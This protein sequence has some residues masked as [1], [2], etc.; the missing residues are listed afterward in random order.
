MICSRDIQE[1][2]LNSYNLYE[3][4]FTSIADDSALYLY[5]DRLRLPLIFYYGHTSAV[6]VNKLMLADLLTKRIN[7]EF[8]TIFETGVDEMFWDDTV[9][10]RIDGKPIV[11]PEVVDVT[12]YR[13]QVKNAILQ[14]INDTPLELPITMESKWWALL[15]GMAHERIHLETSSVLIRQL[16]VNVVTKPP[17]WVYAEMKTGKPVGPNSLVALEGR[18]VQLGKPRNFPSYGWDNEYG[19]SRCL[20]PDFEATKYLVTNEEFLKFVTDKGYERQELWSDIGWKWRCFRSA[21]HPT[22]WVCNKGCKSGCGETLSNYTHCQ[23]RSSD[24]LNEPTFCYRA[25]FDV[26]TLPRDWPVEVNY[27]E[28]KAYCTWM[29]PGY[30]LPTEAEAMLMKGTMPPITERVKCDI[31]HSG[32]PD[33]NINFKYG[34]PSNGSWI[35]T[36]NEASRFARYAFRRHFFQHLGFRMVKSS[37]DI[38]VKLIGPTDQVTKT[39]ELENGSP[40]KSYSQ[41]NVSANS[42]YRY[43]DKLVIEDVLLQE[44]GFKNSLDAVALQKGLSLMEEWSIPAKTALV[45]GSSSGRVAF[46]MSKTFK[47]VLGIDYSNRLLSVAEK[48]KS[49]KST[50]IPYSLGKEVEI[51]PSWSRENVIFKQLTWL[52]MELGSHNMV[53]VTFLERLQNTKAWLYRLWELLKDD[54]LLVITS[55]DT[56]WTAAEL[57]Q[58]LQPR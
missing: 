28:A 50:I 9:N 12:A 40:V 45:L 6:Y 1:Y 13:R 51:D 39:S 32:K 46:D 43:S 49:S 5:P 7:A 37:H 14:M 11:W 2:F 4:L 57:Q 24:E 54:G 22:F 47:K 16:P 52:S 26:I 36:G 33:A 56:T 21:I 8:E 53:L 38:P 44:Y 25:M 31:I 23:L 35:S 34:S 20:V 48:I 55:K 42:Q 41:V 10:Q 30:R 17:T 58:Y 27:H 15:M 18:E 29:G 3:S 19:E